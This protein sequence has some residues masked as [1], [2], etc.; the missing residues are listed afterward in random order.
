MP[1]ERKSLKSN[2]GDIGNLRKP[3]STWRL[4]KAMRWFEKKL[5]LPSDTIICIRP[6]GSRARSDKTLRAFKE[7]WTQHKMR[8]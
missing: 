1:T 4:G 8:R 3:N 6:D 5:G 7:E 2:W